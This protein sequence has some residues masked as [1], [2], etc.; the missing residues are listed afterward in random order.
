M[1]SGFDSNRFA[2]GMPR[3]RAARFVSAAA[4]ATVICGGVLPA[5]TFARQA[6]PAGSPVPSGVSK[7]VADDIIDVSVVDHPD[8]GHQ[9]QVPPDGVIQ[10]PFAGDI[11]VI[12]MTISDLRTRLTKAFAKQFYK[13]LVTIAV[14]SAAETVNVVGVAHG[15]KLPLK[16]GERVLDAIASAGGLP[17]DRPE[18]FKATIIRAATAESQPI[19]VEKLFQ[20]D[21]AQNLTLLSGDTIYI[22]EKAAALT[23]VQVIGEVA[24]PGPVIVP[25]DHSIVTVL[26]S[27]GGPTPMAAL[28]HVTIDR[29]GQ[30]MVVDM[31]KYQ[32]TGFEPTEKIEAGDRLIVPQNKNL[33]YIIGAGGH[34]GTQIYPDDR[35]LTVYSAFSNSGG[36]T[37]G[38]DLSKVKLI[39]PESSGHDKVTLV[40]VSSMLK[41]GDLS[42]DVPLVPGDTIYV[43]PA[44]TRKGLSAGEVI[45]LFSGVVGI[46]YYFKR[47]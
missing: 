14:R 34:T 25:R 27:A 42:A 43:P 16:Q 35:Q 13:P 11:N 19:D 24:K 1:G 37:E 23:T 18:A 4:V 10:V 28:S 15:G 26:Q 6:A 30:T 38:V 12:G 47:H 3:R 5:T 7:I 8:V 29:D 21:A 2:A 33:Y 46:L 44:G 45:G 41:T 32:Q 17:F 40:N 20:G 31:R 9:Y 22:E 39:H 36:S